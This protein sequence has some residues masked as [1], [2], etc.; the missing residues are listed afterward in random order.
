MKSAKLPL[1]FKHKKTTIEK[2]KLNEKPFLDACVAEPITGRVLE[3]RFTE[4]GLQF[5]RAIFWTATSRA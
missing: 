5:Y 3:I 2:T 1:R 4:S